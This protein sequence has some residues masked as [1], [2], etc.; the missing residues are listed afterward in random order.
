[1]LE[2]NFVRKSFSIQDILFL[3]TFKIKMHTYR[4]RKLPV[5]FLWG[6]TDLMIILDVKCKCNCQLVSGGNVEWE[7]WVYGQISEIF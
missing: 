5:V 4:N 6:D 7:V 1:V 3:S 2:C